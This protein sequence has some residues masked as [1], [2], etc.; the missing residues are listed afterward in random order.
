MPANPIFSNLALTVK[1]GG[2]T[3]DYR[4]EQNDPNGSL[5]SYC[6]GRAFEISFHLDSKGGGKTSV[7]VWIKSDDFEKIAAAMM[8]SDPVITRVAFARAI[9][10]SDAA[11]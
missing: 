8:L 6:D 3:S 4:I 1:R 2:I 11:R 5:Q 7:S 10:A 9:I